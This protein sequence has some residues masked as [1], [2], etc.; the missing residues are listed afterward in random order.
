MK[1]PVFIQQQVY[2]GIE[3]IE[4]VNGELSSLSAE[5]LNWKPND[6]SW[7]IAQC[8]EHLII[9]DGL[10]INI[11]EKKIDENFKSG[12][13]EKLNPLKKFWG[14]MLITQTQEKVKKKIKAP[15]LFQPSANE[16]TDNI[17]ARFNIHHDKI[18]LQIKNCL[19]ADLD[20]VYVISPISDLVSY[21][22]RNAITIIT[23]HERRHIN[24]AIRIKQSKDFPT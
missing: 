3:V 7:S 6:T 5:Q 19:D 18:F 16:A 22:L 14:S 13:W 8:L 17:F 24:Q 20:E 10:R 4:K 11:I 2:K 12:G 21:S 15:S 23:V 9:S 1:D